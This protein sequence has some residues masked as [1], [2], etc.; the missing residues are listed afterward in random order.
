MKRRLFIIGMSL[1]IALVMGYVGYRFIRWCRQ[2]RRQ[3]LIFAL[4]VIMAVPTAFA[5]YRFIRWWRSQGID[6]TTI[7]ESS[8][9]ESNT[10]IGQWLTD[11]SSRPSLKTDQGDLCD[12]APFILP[13]AGFIGLL[14]RDSASPYSSAKRHTGIDIF[15]DGAVG[16][17]PVY[18]VY[19][20]YLTR[21]EDWKSTVIIR[22]DDPLQPGRT[23][24]TYYTHM[25]NRAG[26]VD[27]IEND[28]PKGTYGKFV[29]QGTLLGYQG[30]YA[31]TVPGSW[32][33]MHV[34]L[35]IVRDGPEGFLNE[36]SLSNTIDPSPYFDLTLN[37]DQQP[38][39]P[40]RCAK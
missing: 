28:F 35:S 22:H 31:G 33:A 19:D 36:A 24:W 26:T 18:A 29:K 17:V 23:I 30:E 27:F 9:S 8:E 2:Q 3:W 1:L 15:G 34:H 10:Y 7:I 4:I 16:T 21:Q 40:I 14:W 6:F 39:R 5:G 20:G 13:S 12:D 32:I 37:I 25:A 11:A 38:D